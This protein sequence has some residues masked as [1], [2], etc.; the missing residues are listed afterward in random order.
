M[1]RH[2]VREELRL[3]QFDQVL[4]LP[5]LAIDPMQREGTESCLSSAITKGDRHRSSANDNGYR[6]ARRVLCGS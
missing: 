4:H 1:A 6:Y 5:A 3:V 2:A